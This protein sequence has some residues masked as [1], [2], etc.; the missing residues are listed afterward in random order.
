MESAKDTCKQQQ[1]KRIA[2]VSGGSIGR[3]V[4][5]LATAALAV[6][7]VSAIKLWKA[8]VS[9]TNYQSDDKLEKGKGE[10][11]APL[12]IIGKMREDKTDLE[13]EQLKKEE[14]I[15][16]QDTILDDHETRNNNLSEHRIK[17]R[18]IEVPLVEIEYKEE[19]KDTSFAIPKILLDDD[20]ELDKHEERSGKDIINVGVTPND[21]LVNYQVNPQDL[22][23]EEED[24]PIAVVPKLS[25]SVDVENNHKKDEAIIVPK[26][27]H[28]EVEYETKNDEKIMVVLEKPH[29]HEVEYEAIEDETIMALPKKPDLEVEYKEKRAIM[30][31]KTPDFEVE[32]AAEE[33]EEI[34]VVPEKLLLED[35]YEEEKVVMVP[36]EPQF[37]VEYDDKKDEKIMVEPERPHLE[38]EYKEKKAL[39]VSKTPHF[40]VEYNED[41]ASMIIHEKPATEVELESQKGHKFGDDFVNENEELAEEIEMETNMTLGL[42]NEDSDENNS[43]EDYVKVEKEEKSVKNDSEY[44]IKHYEIEDSEVSIFN[45][46]KKR[47]NEYLLDQKSKRIWLWA[48]VVFVLAIVAPMVFLD[49]GFFYAFPYRIRFCGWFHRSFSN[50]YVARRKETQMHT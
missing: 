43:I 27:P 41:K 45:F 14:Q 29:L 37:E 15:S 24:D 36:K 12:E 32:Y 5:V 10:A 16:A 49:V 7:S 50:Y 11:D 31:P 38:D 28:F 23:A 2:I 47:I 9:K 18:E 13:N 42:E 22:E 21:R 4:V 26:E 39:T 17:P 20:E 19:E 6:A 25:S 1:Q 8:K 40:E 46:T 34:M 35:E 44:A 3:V 48:I 33:D 30:V